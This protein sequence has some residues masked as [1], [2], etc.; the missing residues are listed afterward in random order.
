LVD[1]FGEKGFVVVG[2]TNEPEDKT[3]AF[4]E[5]TGMKGIVAFM[6]QA[7]VTNDMKQYG[8]PG[9]PSAALVGP[10]GKLVWKGHP[11]GLEA[12]IIKS[13]L[14]G[15][16][17]R[18]ENPFAIQVELPGKYAAVQKKLADGKLGTAWKALQAA[19]KRKVDPDDASKLKAAVKKIEEEFKNHLRSADT[20]LG[21]G[22]YYDAQ[23]TWKSMAK[24]YRGYER[25]A[26]VKEKLADLAR[27]TSVRK[28]LDA[29][30]RIATALAA[31]DK[32]QTKRAI[33][34]LKSILT[35]PLKD[36]KEAKRARELLE[37]LEGGKG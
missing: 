22:R 21:E 14:K 4:V 11:S 7:S 1:Q 10:Q 6:S 9:L 35:G 28:E 5:S 2:I 27:N 32:K 19:L 16:Q 33:Q 20:A 17:I 12:S 24:H 29:G 36:T 31:H 30:R 23:T 26:E 18:P 25:T 3:M 8:F 13:N 15:V 34:G 37:K